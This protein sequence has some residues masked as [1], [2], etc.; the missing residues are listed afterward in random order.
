MKTIA[1]L[2]G[3]N[4]SSSINTQLVN[5]AGSLIQKN[6]VDSIDLRNYELPIYSSDIENE[7]GLPSTLDSLIKKFD[8]VD[9]FMFSLPEHNGYMTAFFKN[10]TDWLSRADGK[11][12]KGKPVLL[13]AS[14]PGAGGA[15]SGMEKTAHV[16]G[17][18][19]ADIK[20]Q[21]S[22]GSFYD[23]FDTQN[24]TIKDEEK[25]T[26]LKALVADFED[27]I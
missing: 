12:F 7:E 21:Y 16:F 1:T 24:N 27:G 17:Y 15:K 11:F 26:E 2:S 8:K 18:F 19:N 23:N 14:S 25:L 13:L 22:L 5:F 4:S 20:G 6:K 10:I 3:S 9:A